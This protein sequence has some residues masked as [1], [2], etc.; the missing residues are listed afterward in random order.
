MTVLVWGPHL[1]LVT[2][3]TGQ[4]D[5]GVVPIKINIW[6]ILSFIVIVYTTEC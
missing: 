4:L 1:G 2:L 5:V 3:E 6:R